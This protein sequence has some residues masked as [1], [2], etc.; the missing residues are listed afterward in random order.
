MQAID[1]TLGLR[2]SAEEELLGADYVEHGIPLGRRE[3]APSP[4]SPLLHTHLGHPPS[5]A[6]QVPP[7]SAPAETLQATCVLID[8]AQATLDKQDTTV[9]LQKPSETRRENQGSRNYGFTITFSSDLLRNRNDGKELKTVV[10]GNATV[11][12]NKDALSGGEK[13]GPSAASY[14]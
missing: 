3:D 5:P 13:A 2:V 14:R 4:Q 8:D 1:L 7:V 12:E 6:A 11:Y 9:Y 10:K